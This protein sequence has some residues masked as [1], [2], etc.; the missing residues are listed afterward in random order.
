MC[1]HQKWWS[2]YKIQWILMEEEYNKDP[3]VTEEL[4]MVN[5]QI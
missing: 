5:N 3:S 1:I 4:S 2:E